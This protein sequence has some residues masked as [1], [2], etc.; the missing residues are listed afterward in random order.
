M[1]YR[2]AL[3]LFWRPV[4]SKGQGFTYSRMSLMFFCYLHYNE[5]LSRMSINDY[6]LTYTNLG[7]QKR[8]IMF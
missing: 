3:E 6:K 8:L 1:G 5:N 2:E 4:Y 7:G